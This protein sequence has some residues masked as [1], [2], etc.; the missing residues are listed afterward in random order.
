MVEYFLFLLATLFFLLSI[1]LITYKSGNHDADLFLKIIGLMF[2]VPSIYIVL[3]SL[4]IIKWI[5]I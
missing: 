3:E 1:K 2:L 4:K 5:Y